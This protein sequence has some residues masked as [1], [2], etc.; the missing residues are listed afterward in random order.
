MRVHCPG[1]KRHGCEGVVIV[2]KK[3]HGLS[4]AIVLL[5]NVE[6]NLKKWTCPIPGHEMMRLDIIS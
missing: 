6:S 4:T 2:V 3:E 1:S 5:E